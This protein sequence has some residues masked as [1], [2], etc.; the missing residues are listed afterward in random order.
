LSSI[1]IDP[2]QRFACSQCGR[3]CHRFQVVVSEAE[4][5][6]YRRKNAAA[7]FR[8]GGD[9]EGSTRDPFE[10]IPGVAGFHLIRKR[11]DGACGFLSADNRCRIHE[12][13]GAAKKPLTCRVFPYSFH[14]AAEAT[15]VTASFGC[16]SI[17]GNHGP[18]VDTAESRA[19]IE[20]LR[21]EWFAAHPELTI[22]VQ[23]V[24]GRTIDA[25]SSRVIRDNLVAMLNRDENDI[26][27]NVAR[28]AAAIDDL[29]RS[30][31]LALPDADFAEYVA[32]TLPHRASQPDAPP[33]RAADWSGRLLQHAFL[34]TVTAIRADLEHPG[35]SRSRLRWL[36]LRLLAHFHRLAPGLERVNLTARHRVAVDINAPEL[37]PIVVHYLRSTLTTLGGRGRPLIDE[38]AIAVSFLN[39][40]IALAA[41]NADAAGTTVDAAIFT[42]GLM[43]SSDVSHARNALLEWVLNRTSAGSEALWQLAS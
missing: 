34:Y 32:L 39:A 11:A 40:A 24:R 27:S 30:P 20:S 29:T 18:L 4:I 3:C 16:P 43:E 28:I 42:Q 5:D 21:K 15:V 17:V 19:G 12:Q 14:A 26:R 25:R 8:E 22:P 33:R 6:L 13:L 35:Q 7:W 2:N 41:M 37:R 1:R 23:F 9:A 38:L 36:R 10:Q 31:V